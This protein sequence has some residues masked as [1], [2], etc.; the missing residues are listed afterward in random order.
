MGHLRQQQSLLDSIP[1]RSQN[2]ETEKRG[3]V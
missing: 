2:D 1:L 3:Q